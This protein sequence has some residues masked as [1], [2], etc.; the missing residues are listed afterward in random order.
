MKSSLSVI[1]LVAMAAM[2][3]CCS[4]QAVSTNRHPHK[5]TPCD[6]QAHDDTVAVTMA[7]VNCKEIY[8]KKNKNNI[9]WYSP[10]GTKLQVIFPDNPFTDLRCGDNECTAYWVE[11][12]ITSDQWFKYSTS[13]DGV[14]TGDPNV[15]IKP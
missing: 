14:P 9:V 11:K 13:I 6:H 12:D 3:G 5:P 7:G 15:I 8:I 4:T 1:A 2:T 10:D